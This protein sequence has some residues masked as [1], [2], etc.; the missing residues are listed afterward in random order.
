MIPDY[1]KLPHN[2]AWPTDDIS[3]VSA[4]KVSKKGRVR[5]KEAKPREKDRWA[6]LKCTTKT[7]MNVS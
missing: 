3:S 6:N 4:W 7:D 5:L 2:P 1:A